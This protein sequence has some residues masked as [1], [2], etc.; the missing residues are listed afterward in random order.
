MF[1]LGINLKK[2]DFT[3]GG[4]MIHFFLEHPLDVNGICDF[5]FQV[6]HFISILSFVN[7]TQRPVPLPR[8]LYAFVSSWN[9]H[10]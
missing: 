10:C 3:R 2:A 7:F 9:R 4:G 1:F 6:T 5:G 8:H